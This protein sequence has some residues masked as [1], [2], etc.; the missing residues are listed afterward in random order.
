[1]WEALKPLLYTIELQADIN[2]PSSL[3]QLTAVS[4]TK[5]TKNKANLDGSLLSLWL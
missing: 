2:H 3:Y 1:M 4:V 5:S